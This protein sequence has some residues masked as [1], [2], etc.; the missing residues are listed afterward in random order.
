[1]LNLNICNKMIWLFII[2]QLVIQHVGCQ[3]KNLS[4]FCFILSLSLSI[5]VVFQF[6]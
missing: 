3:G 4:Y 6:E 5:L 2:I 1:M